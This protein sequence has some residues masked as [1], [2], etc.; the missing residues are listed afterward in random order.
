MAAKVKEAPLSSLLAGAGGVAA[1]CYAMGCPPQKMCY[2]AAAYAAGAGV[3][4]MSPLCE[5]DKEPRG[6]GYGSCNALVGEGKPYAITRDHVAGL[7]VMV[8]TM[9]YFDAD[10]KQIAAAAV[11]ATGGSVAAQYGYEAY[12]K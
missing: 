7:V 8:G 6:L 9:M 11:R 12:N 2:G 4:L 10:W 1:G 5:A 3:A